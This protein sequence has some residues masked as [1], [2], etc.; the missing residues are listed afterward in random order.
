MVA[1]NRVYDN[2]GKHLESTK[3]CVVFTERLRLLMAT[4]VSLRLTM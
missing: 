1:V 3:L 4:T 2:T